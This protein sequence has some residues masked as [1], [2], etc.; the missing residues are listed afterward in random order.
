M[1]KYLAAHW[2]HIPA[3]SVWL[4]EWDRYI[5][6][7]DVD[8]KRSRYSTSGAMSPFAQIERSAPI[9]F[10]DKVYFVRVVYDKHSKQKMIDIRQYDLEQTR[11]ENNFEPTVYGI[12]LPID[13]WETLWKTAYKLIKKWDRK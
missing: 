4:S 6:A 13:N 3:V 10:D 7:A 8:R 12:S 1:R 5:L 2:K 9:V 11:T